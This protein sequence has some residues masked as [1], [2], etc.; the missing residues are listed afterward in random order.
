[1]PQR[2]IVRRL[3]STDVALATEMV[4]AFKSAASTTKLSEFLARRENILLAALGDGSPCGFLLAYALDRIDRE[5]PM[6]CLYELSVA[7]SWRGR[8]IGRELVNSLL[9]L[10]EEIGAQKIWAVTEDSNAAAAGL[11]EST[12]ARTQGSGAD[13]V[14]VWQRPLWDPST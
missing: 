3:T 9:R 4:L 12:G 7:E 2:P 6:I 14:F 13:Q 11:Y 5:H 10:G 8:G 1:M